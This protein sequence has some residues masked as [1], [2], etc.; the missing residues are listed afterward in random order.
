MGT[1]AELHVIVSHSS[2]P[3]YAPASKAYEVQNTVAD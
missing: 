3:P 2:T 1:I